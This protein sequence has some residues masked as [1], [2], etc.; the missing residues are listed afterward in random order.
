[1]LWSERS[2]ASSA[3][4]GIRTKSSR[5]CAPFETTRVERARHEVT[6][7][8]T[9]PSLWYR[10]RRTGVGAVV[11]LQSRLQVF[12]DR[13]LTTASTT[14][15]C[16]KSGLNTT[17]CASSALHLCKTMPDAHADATLAASSVP[18]SA[19]FKRPTKLVDD[20]TSLARPLLSAYMP[21]ANSCAHGGTSC[22]MISSTDFI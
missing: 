12:R 20:A 2:T 16:R 11:T 21:S 7:T 17:A 1:M 6:L 3:F 5:V 18:A 8:G 10:V 22:V 15:E 14:N 9:P 4:R 13:S 19:D